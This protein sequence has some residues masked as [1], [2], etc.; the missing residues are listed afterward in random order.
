ME[1][2]LAFQ[3]LANAGLIAGS[4]V[5]TTG[6]G[7]VTNDHVIGYNVPA[8]KLSGAGWDLYDGCWGSSACYTEAEVGPFG[9]VL[10]F[11]SD[12]SVHQRLLGRPLSTEDVWNIDQ[13]IDDG[14]PHSGLALVV[15]D[16]ACTTDATKT[17]YDLD[18]T[19]RQ[20]GIVFR[21]LF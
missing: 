20:C 21:H 3:Q 8:S 15:G 17:A 5:G 2:Y 6:P 14:L 18:E 12:A 9:Q 11:G 16:I 13:K 7:H 4:Y 19:A 10:Q 1:P